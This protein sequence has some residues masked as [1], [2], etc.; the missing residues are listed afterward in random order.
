MDSLD[1]VAT[2]LETIHKGEV[3][4]VFNKD[5]ELLYP[6]DVIADIPHGNKIALADC[7]AGETVVK[8]GAV[9]GECTHPFK[10]GRLVHVHNVK[11]LKVDVPTSIRQEIMHQ[12]HLEP[13]EGT[14]ND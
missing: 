10:K 7:G 1:T 3:A 2:A 8:Y 12:M 11:S 6:I 4:S 5:G 13:G 14:T 9:I